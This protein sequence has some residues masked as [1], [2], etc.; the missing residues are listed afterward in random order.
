[1]IC[2][3]ILFFILSNLIKIKG[4]K[5][6]PKIDNKG[7]KLTVIFC[8]LIIVYYLIIYIIGGITHTINVYDY[9]LNKTNI[10][11]TLG[12]QLLLS[13]PSE[14]LLF[15]ALPIALYIHFMKSDSKSNYVTAIILSAFLFA[16]AHINFRE[17]IIPWIQVCYAFVYGL[18]YGYVFIK[19]KSVIYPMIMHSMSNV[20]SV[21][22][23]YLY[24]LILN[25][26]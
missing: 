17:F 12:F 11:G 2:S 4:F 22:G 24:M 16:L 9:E 23:C 1:M 5:I 3:L 19:S 14:E 18:A 20:I 7:I 8:S 25:G 6:L 26:L 15:R 10:I 13:G 21:G